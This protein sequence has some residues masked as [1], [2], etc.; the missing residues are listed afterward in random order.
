MEETD[1]STGVTVESTGLALVPQA[2]APQVN[3]D[4][5]QLLSRLVVGLSLYGGEAL[6]TRLRA[7]QQRIDARGD[8][9]GGDVVPDD[10]TMTEVVGYLAV[11]MVMRAQKR[12][13]RSLNWGL[14]LSMNTAGW[15]L[16][17]FGRL[18]DNFFMRPL[19]E[20]VERRIWELMQ[21]SQAAIVEGRREVYASRKLA[22]ET[23][24]DAF[25]EAIQALAESPEVTNAAMRVTAGQG[26]SLAGTAIGSAQ[27]LGTSADDT[28]E[29]IVR[30]LLR[31][32]P[33][34]ELP[35]SPLLDKP[36]TMY[37]PQGGPDDSE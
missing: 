37:G 12:L 24:G 35:P 19:R 20:P 1:G 23:V 21:E 7:A 16:G 36:L 27:T 13:A 22:N 17:T 15:A 32:R 33:R 25:D 2:Q 30:R 34:K 10:E 4:D 14:D 9:A 6:L 29:G 5:V 18:T 8:L 31:R 11:G 28:A 26:A 3:A